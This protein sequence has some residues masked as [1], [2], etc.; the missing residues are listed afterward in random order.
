MPVKTEKF[1]S[2]LTKKADVFQQREKSEQTADIA[3][4]VE[5][6][7]KIKQAGKEAKQQNIEQSGAGNKTLIIVAVAAIAGYFFLKKKKH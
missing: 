5:A 4:T 6:Q 1:L 3:Q 7:A 2:A